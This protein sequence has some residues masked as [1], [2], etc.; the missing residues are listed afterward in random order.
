MVQGKGFARVGMKQVSRASAATM[1][2]R[3]E[4]ISCRTLARA[5]QRTV[6][7]M[8]KLVHDFLHSGASFVLAS[9]Q[10]PG[11]AAHASQPVL[12]GMLLM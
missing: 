10:L 9:Q 7:G 5:E 4:K 3:S 2:A 6:S 12:L 8:Q 11:P 1:R